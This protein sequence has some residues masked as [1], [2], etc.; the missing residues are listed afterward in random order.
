MEEMREMSRNESRDLLPCWV[1]LLVKILARSPRL[2]PF[3]AVW[4]PGV[5]EEEASCPS[6]RCCV[7][8]EKGRDRRHSGL[9]RFGEDPTAALNG[10]C[11]SRRLVAKLM[12]CQLLNWF[13]E[14]LILIFVPNCLFKCGYC[15]NPCSF[16]G[17][18]KFRTPLLQ[19]SPRL[20]LFA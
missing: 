3:N 10:G 19:T 18:K 15:R 8:F 6:A 1:W 4:P 5:L 20:T 12:P 7:V 13:I 9:Y 14:T 16:F 17:D 2:G 11:A